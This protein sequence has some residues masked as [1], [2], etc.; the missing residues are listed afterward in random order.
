LVIFLIHEWKTYKHSFGSSRLCDCVYDFFFNLQEAAQELIEAVKD[1]SVV[2][3]G[4]VATTMET[5][6]IGKNDHGSL[7]TIIKFNAAAKIKY[8]AKHSFS[9]VWHDFGRVEN[10]TFTVA[11]TVGTGC[12]AFAS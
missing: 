8:Q 1:L 12:P 11:V 6:T 10:Y 4:T 5:A 2:V 3:Q 9:A 7:S